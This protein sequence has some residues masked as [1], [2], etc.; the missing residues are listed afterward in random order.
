[1]A[2]SFPLAN[3]QPPPAAIADFG[4][5]SGRKHHSLKPQKIALFVSQRNAAIGQG[6]LNDF[7]GR[8]HGLRAKASPS[9][10]CVKDAHSV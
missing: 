6:L 7:G 5:E 8:L 3:T 4:L 1:M 9:L 2:R 10:D